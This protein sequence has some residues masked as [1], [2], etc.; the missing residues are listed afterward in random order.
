[1]SKHLVDAGVRGWQDNPMNIVYSKN[2][3]KAGGEDRD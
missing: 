2:L 3:A 1:V